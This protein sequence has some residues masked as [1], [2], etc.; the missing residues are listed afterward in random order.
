MKQ[1]PKARTVIPVRRMRRG[2]RSVAEL[3]RRVHAIGARYATDHPLQEHMDPSSYINSLW[4]SFYTSKEIGPISEGQYLSISRAFLAGYSEKMGMPT[5]NLVLVPTRKTIGAVVTVS[6]EEKTIARVLNELQ[7]LP[8]QELI[9]VINGS[10]DNS[11]HIARQCPQATIVHYPSLVGHDVGRSI[12]AKLSSSDMMLFLDGDIPIQTE[13]LVPFIRAIDGGWD[14]ALNDISP[15]IG[16]FA[17]RDGVSIV[18]QFVNRVQ[19]RPELQANSMTAIPHMLSRKALEV[20]GSAALAVPPKAQAKAIRNGL[21]ICAPASID[22]VTSNKPT[23]FNTGTANPV[24]NLIVGDHLEALHMLLGE[25]GSRLQF[26][27]AHRTRTALA[28]GSV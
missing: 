25:H 18:K 2:S 17:H 5:P 3:R 21:R 7:R 22:V 8:L 16:L 9:V 15:Y 6:N 11:V 13:Q 4:H 20:I 26:K 28:G 12:G 10:T 27:D 23:R 14:I 19:G 24:S 1:R